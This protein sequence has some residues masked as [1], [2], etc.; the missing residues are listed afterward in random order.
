MDSA[1][2]N[3]PTQTTQSIHDSTNKNL[4]ITASYREQVFKAAFWSSVGFGGVAFWAALIHFGQ[5]INP[6]NM[7]GII[8]VFSGL[9]AFSAL[10]K[11]SKSYR[12][13][14]LILLMFLQGAGC[15][16]LTHHLAIAS[17]FLFSCLMITALLAERKVAYIMGFIALL[18]LLS[19]SVLL[20]PS[21]ESE[22]LLQS[23]DLSPLL[24]GLVYVLII[25]S[26]IIPLVQYINSHQ[27]ILGLHQQPS[28]KQEGDDE[29]E[30]FNQSDI[31]TY[32]VPMNPSK[33]R[34]ISNLIAEINPYHPWEKISFQV[35]SWI[36]QEYG[37][38]QIEIYLAS[39]ED[40]YQHAFIF[41]NSNNNIE[42]SFETLRLEDVPEAIR[43]L[44]TA[45][46]PFEKHE[47]DTNEDVTSASNDHIINQ[48]S[49][50]L[51]VKTNQ[52][53]IGA[54]LLHQIPD[55]NA[56]MPDIAELELLADILALIWINKRLTGD[57]IRFSENTHWVNQS[58]RRLSLSET[59][60]EI[61]SILDETL[62]RSSFVTI[63][64]QIEKNTMHL[65]AVN[66]PDNPG[67]TPF[68]SLTINI[69]SGEGIVPNTPLLLRQLYNQ[70]NLPLELLKFLHQLNLVSTAFL[71][72][73]PNNQISRL[74]I[75]GSRD[76][77]ALT[78][79]SIQP[80]I[81]LASYTTTAIEK[82]ITRQHLQRR[83]TALQSLASI[84]Q[85]IS[86]VTDLNE[87]FDT[88][89]EQVMQVVG[90]VDLAIALYD[91]VSD[92]ISI[93]YAH[94]G[95]QKLTLDPFPLGQGLTSILIRTQR[96]LML[97]KDTERRARELGAKISGASAKSWLGVPLIVSGEVLGAIILQDTQNEQR[98]N[99]DDLHLITT[100]ASQVAITVRNVRLLQETNRR[101]E[102]ERIVSNITSKI[103][104]SSDIES[105]A[106]NALLELGRALQV[107]NGTILLQK[108]SPDDIYIDSPDAEMNALQ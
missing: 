14:S 24:T 27:S 90:E 78:P 3:Q 91:P 52:E 62:N 11:V 54:L 92:M 104:S 94:E 85:A 8:L 39:V 83:V 84:S 49:L 99:E 100:L 6:L 65:H 93:P 50:L 28:R 53:L 102:R 59:N 20:Y 26:G 68:P 97:V 80:Y 25:A 56:L 4:D 2:L 87:L 19:G 101:A 77:Q 16:I 79:N 81:Y 86:V 103:W 47:S 9:V 89:H 70:P 57:E 51:P 5:Q 43:K 18:A 34:K 74:F 29:G 10:P 71:P 48:S 66:D 1:E 96:P 13:A 22:V 63:Q 67:Q 44:L 21:L 69:E 45:V 35:L 7:A 82:I 46:S 31:L 38:P 76:K 12:T 32:P 36:R 58:I 41:I 15:L 107:S 98:F 55:E 17:L 61:Y 72:V 88:I 42:E 40:T 30:A 37:Y 23:P 73:Q 105:I 60:D 108:T 75:L 106:R 33:T 95:G 64:F